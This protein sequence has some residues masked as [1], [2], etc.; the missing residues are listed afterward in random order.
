MESD[1]INHLRKCHECQ[2]YADKIHTPPMS[3]NILLAPWP[4]SMW[5]LDVIGLIEP[6]ALN[7][8]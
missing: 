6:K 4:F 8:H 3:L 7:G 5:G 1:C 2:I